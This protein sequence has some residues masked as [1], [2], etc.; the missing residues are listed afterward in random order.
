[1]STSAHGALAPWYLAPMPAGTT[2]SQ[3]R[4]RHDPQETEREI[5]TAA[6]S[7]LRELPFREVTVERIMRETG[8]KRPAFYAHFRDRYEI[9][10]RV[11]QGIRT[12]LLEPSGRWLDPAGG[13]E[14]L[15]L[16]ME[17]VVD[18]YVSQGPLIA[19]LGDASASDERLEQTYRGLV[20]TFV[21][22]TTAKVESE[23]R[24]GRIDATLDA[25]ETAQALVW[26]NERYLGVAFG[27]GP[28]PDPA[29]CTAALVHIW[30]T[31]LYG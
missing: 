18:F 21:D 10:L 25:A 28:P 3:R 6:E 29:R 24:A 11:V 9:V 19:A 23:Q 16:A 20:Q 4:P 13:R 12:A 5:L 22:T 15:R 8:L 31:T 7:L 26:L 14:E 27:S 17:G 1:M 30:E 2:P